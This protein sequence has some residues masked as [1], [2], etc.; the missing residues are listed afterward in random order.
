VSWAFGG[1][2]MLAEEL[3]HLNAIDELLRPSQSCKAPLTVRKG[4]IAKFLRFDSTD[5][6]LRWIHRCECY[7]L[8]GRT[9]E[10]RCVMYTAFHR[11]NGTQL[12]YH[13]LPNNDDLLTWEQF[14][15]LIAA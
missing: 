13:R 15:L 12:W 6:Q 4:T 3:Q 2:V 8:T 11:H 7:F 9:L 1:K 14:V 10:N 5:D